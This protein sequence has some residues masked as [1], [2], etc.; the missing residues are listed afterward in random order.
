MNPFH[1]SSERLEAHFKEDNSQAVQIYLLT[2]LHPNPCS[3]AQFR[4]YI[5]GRA[6]FSRHAF[7]RGRAAFRGLGLVIGVLEFGAHAPT[8]HTVRGCETEVADF[9]TTVGV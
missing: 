6:H 7:F 2:V 9:D 5:Q 3:L 1:G 4:S 8:C